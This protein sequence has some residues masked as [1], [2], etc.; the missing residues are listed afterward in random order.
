MSREFTLAA[1]EEWEMSDY[2]P[3]AAILE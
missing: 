3:L 1:V 2:I